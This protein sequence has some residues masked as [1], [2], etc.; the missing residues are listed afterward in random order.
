MSSLLYQ[1]RT[2]TQER[3]NNSY[4]KRRRKRLYKDFP[5][6]ETYLSCNI[7]LNIVLDIDTIS[8]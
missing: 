3:I 7:E 4:Q 8:Q 5:I 2:M 1:N 6:K